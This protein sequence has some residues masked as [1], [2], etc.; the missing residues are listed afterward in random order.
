MI[1]PSSA[2]VRSRTNSDSI[3]SLM[4]LPLNGI[5]GSDIQSSS[6]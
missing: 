1:C 3:S 4:V 2:P 6:T 5:D